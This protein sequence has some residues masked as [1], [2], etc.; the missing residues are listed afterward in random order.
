MIRKLLALL[1][2]AGPVSAEP[3]R[4][5][6]GEHGDFTRLVVELPSA[7][8][9]TVGRTPEGYAFVVSGPTLP[10]YDLTAVWQRIA[11]TRVAA[12]DADASTGTLTVT[13][14]CDC[15][16]FPFEY[17][18]GVVVLDIKPG[19][20]PQGSAFETAL[21][22][23]TP[24]ANPSPE[25]ESTAAYDWLSDP[26]KASTRRPV[27]TLP[28]PL[29]TGEVSLEPIRDALLEQIARGAAD[30]VVDMGLPLPGHAAPAADTVVLPWSDIRI[31]ERP[32]ILVS[33]PDAF[34]EGMLPASA[35]AADDDLD[36]AAWGETASPIDL[37]STARSGLYGEFDAPDPAAVLRS[38]RL[39]LYLGF[40]AEAAQQA[41][42][43]DQES[44]AGALALYRSMAR[45]VDGES[46]PDTPFATMLDCDGPAA[47]W[48]ALA[49]DRLPAGPGV[50]RDAILRAFLALPPHLR[51]HLGSPLAEKFLA[52]DDAD[53]VRVI[54][55]AIERAPDA[56][57][58]AVAL[59]D[60]ESDLHL[61]DT[62]A[63]RDHALQAVALD[64]NQAEALVALVETHFRQLDPI[65]SD[66]PDALL[67]L[68]GETS[69]TALAGAV[70]RALVLSLGLSGQAEAAFLDP[71]ATGATLVDLWRVV[72]DRASDDEF[73]RHAVLPSK[74]EPP[75]LE[76]A[77]DLAIAN[78][79]LALGFPD[80]AL[81]WTGPVLP[82]D[83]PDLRLAA[84][85]A[86]LGR[87]DARR[88]VELL[89]GLPGT[90]AATLRA[91]ALLQLDDLAAAGTSLAA[92]G[93]TDAALRTSLWRGDW[94]DLDPSAPEAWQT[95]AQLTKPAV[96]DASTGLLGRGADAVAASTASRAAIE[97]L[98]GS[99]AAPGGG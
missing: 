33:D 47:L 22:K 27:T 98:L 17:Q 2:L 48:A 79:L 66:V 4:V 16:L 76:A 92:A 62:E 25:D 31:G 29:P 86:E 90:K 8:D 67:A 77:L 95:A 80:A 53:A 30:G 23:Q 88:A 89:S 63:A 60:A 55:D 59:L 81:V 11:R 70:D 52:R 28:L 43:L 45:L 1:S 58:G 61:G 99:V 84:A 75:Q 7:A 44:E 54:R 96:T 35:C 32:G 51:S 97:A 65:T 64:G 56:D 34:A 57:P 3:L 49:R 87:R 38:V 50:N 73:L 85:E 71:A 36:L 6:S 10:D 20:A 18:P 69:G 26:T 91:K 83:A 21:P 9:W 40:G 82:T 12:L 72:R 93:Q 41:G 68:R 14:G 74:T 94:S 15:H 13:L 5:Y 42:L 39:H 78:R 24:A 19:P 37:L 46:D